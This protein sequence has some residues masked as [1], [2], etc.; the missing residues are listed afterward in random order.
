MS[1]SNLYIVGGG[2]GG[3]G[4][5]MTSIALLDWLLHHKKFV[6]VTLVETDDS[7][8][9]VY[10]AYKKVE[11]V[12]SVVLNLDHEDGWVKLMNMM[13]DW[14]KSGAQIVLNTAARATPMLEKY[15]NDLQ[16]G[17]DELNI[18]LH[19]LW[20]INRQR[21]SLILLNGILKVAKLNATVV[22]NLY[23]GS[24]DKYVLF[25]D[26]AVAKI[27]KTIDL[28][29]LN[30]SVSDKIY[31]DRLP[32]HETDKLQFGERVALSRFRNDAY[33]QFDKLA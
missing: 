6:N 12:T 26:S 5:T 1:K 3:V 27:V 18:G 16:A 8:P 13:P 29:E 31:V 2:K 7:N 25:A 28:P 23:F 14:S 9:D 10:K 20:P 33:L 15:M 11:A 24:A 22:K 4:K 17:A 30:D 21:D 19:F 32:L